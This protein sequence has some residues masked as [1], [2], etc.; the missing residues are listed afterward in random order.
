[1]IHL[2]VFTLFKIEYVKGGR[3]TMY[4]INQNRNKSARQQWS[5]EIDK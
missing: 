1:M 5:I 4:Q 3:K 2:I